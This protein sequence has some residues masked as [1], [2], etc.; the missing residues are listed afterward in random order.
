MIHG[1]QQLRPCM[2][3]KQMAQFEKI[4]TGQGRKEEGSLLDSIP[5][6]YEVGLSK[7]DKEISRRLLADVFV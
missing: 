5:R 1:T 7:I 6:R 3:Q 2:A 4:S